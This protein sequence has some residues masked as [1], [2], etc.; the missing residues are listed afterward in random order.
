MS[1]VQWLFGF[2]WRSDSDYKATQ[3]QLGL[4]LAELDNNTKDNVKGKSI[5]EIIED[6]ITDNS[7]DNIKDQFKDLVKDNFK[8][9]LG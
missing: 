3:P 8:N 1:S 5:K 9:K 6:N 2:R 4:G 7:K